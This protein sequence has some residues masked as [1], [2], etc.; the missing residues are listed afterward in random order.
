MASVPAGAALCGGARWVRG[1]TPC[2]NPVACTVLYFGDTDEAI[3]SVKQAF[4]FPNGYILI[5]FLVSIPDFVSI[6]TM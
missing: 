2:R 6:V 4:V 3:D 5:N 1:V